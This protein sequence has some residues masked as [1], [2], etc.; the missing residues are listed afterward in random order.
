MSSWSSPGPAMGA[1]ADAKRRFKV[2][3]STATLDYWSEALEAPTMYAA[4]GAWI[5]RIGQLPPG[6]RPA[7]PEDPERAG[8]RLSVVPEE[9][10]P[11]LERELEL[12]LGD[13]PF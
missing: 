4:L 12:L 10:W 3:I 11:A 5:R 9:S 6:L 1:G 13:P 2:H 8:W 7:E